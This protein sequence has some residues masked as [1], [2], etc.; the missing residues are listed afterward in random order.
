MVESILG[1]VVLFLVC[2]L[3]ISVGGLEAQTNFTFDVD[4][5]CEDVELR[6]LA[7]SFFSR[8]LRELGD[9]RV[10]ETAAP[11]FRVEAIAFI[12]KRNWT[13]SVVITAPFGGSSVEGLDAET[14]AS[15]SGYAQTVE[16]SLIRG[17]STDD[18][19]E[20]IGDIVRTL[21]REVLKP[22]RKEQ[23]KK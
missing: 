13:M 6:G 12:V 20:Q 11:D 4:V 10:A 1:R 2:L 8:E 22:R 5:S 18:L 9:V 17:N 23:K 3:S 16:H 7:R 14:A 21:N 19:G 15:L